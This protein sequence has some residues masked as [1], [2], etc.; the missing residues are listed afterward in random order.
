MPDSDVRTAPRPE[1]VS[2]E[3]V[4]AEA[5][6]AHGEPYRGHVVEPPQ[7]RLT[8]SWQ[9]LAPER[10]SDALAMIWLGIGL[11]V[12]AGLSALLS[13]YLL[14]LALPAIGLTF[15]GYQRQYVATRLEL[16]GDQVRVVDVGSPRSCALSQVA[17][18]DACSSE[19]THRVMITLRDGGHRE[20]L[21]TAAAD[22][23]RYVVRVLDERRGR[24]ATT[25]T[26][27]GLVLADAARPR[28]VLALV[29]ASRT[30]V[31]FSLWRWSRR[32][33]VG[34]L[35]RAA[36]LGL[37]IARLIE[38]SYVHA[39]FLFAVAVYGAIDVVRHAKLRITPEGL[40][41][42]SRIGGGVRTVVVPRSRLAGARLD[43]VEGHVCELV[44]RLSDGTVVPLLDVEDRGD[45]AYLQRRLR[46]AL[47]AAPSP[48]QLTAGDLEAAR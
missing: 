40:R 32:S 19:S 48:A 13:V 1:G 17:A 6:A 31:S 15:A 24:M 45:V 44:A 2:V 9:T 33:T 12:F 22:T 23:A 28:G 11:L 34:M 20:L 35:F 7:D 21:S 38:G 4:L 36:Y 18:V 30:A 14:V 5:P 10:R 43:L 25:S 3:L 46:T 16:A 8:L 39:A 37:G 27:T 26:E 29:R 41:L 47:A 42:R